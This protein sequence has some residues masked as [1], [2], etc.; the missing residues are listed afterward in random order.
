MTDSRQDFI[1]AYQIVCYD[2]S[3]GQSLQDKRDISYNESDQNKLCDTWLLV[4]TG[5]TIFKTSAS[6]TSC[7]SLLRAATRS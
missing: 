3:A 5:F 1:S 4:K 6:L 7:F 2:T